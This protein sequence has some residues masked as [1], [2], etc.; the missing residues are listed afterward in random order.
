MPPSEPRTS[1]ISIAAD[2]VNLAIPDDA[3]T[4]TASRSGGPGGQNVNKVSSRVTLEFDVRQ[5][6]LLSAEQRRRIEEKLAARINKD[7]I[8]RVVS[9][10]TR[11]Q[12]MNR[13]DATARFRE[14]LTMALHT[15]PPRVA[16]RMPRAVREGR[17]SDKKKRGETKRFRRTLME[18]A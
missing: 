4:F 3:L 1:L 9:Q 14:L 13:G 2:G 6:P 11:S 10:K 12:E 7:G 16:T 8:L 17:L 5:S 15:E 18:N